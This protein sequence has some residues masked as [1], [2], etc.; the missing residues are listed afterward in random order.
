[1]GVHVDKARGNDFSLGID[2]LGAN[3]RQ[4][5]SQRGDHSILD[6]HIP[7]ERGGASAVVDIAF[8]DYQVVVSHRLHLCRFTSE[9]QRSKARAA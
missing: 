5:G 3:A 6:S 7:T 8:A 1:V 4:I 9:A 2:F